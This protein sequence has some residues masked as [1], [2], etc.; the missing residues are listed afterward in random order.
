MAGEPRVSVRMLVDESTSGIPDTKV[1]TIL[2]GKKLVCTGTSA[3][4]TKQ[5][6]LQ[7]AEEV[8][9]DKSPL[10][11]DWYLD[12]GWFERVFSYGLERPGSKRSPSSS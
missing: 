4:G 8:G 5:W 12:E 7:D 9:L 3:K 1:G 11:N 2:T 6:I 10:L